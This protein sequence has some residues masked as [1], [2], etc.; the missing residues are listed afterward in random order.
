MGC[1]VMAAFLLSCLF[2]K[3]GT[4]S[5]HVEHGET[6]SRPIGN[7]LWF[8]LSPEPMSTAEDGEL[9]SRHHVQRTVTTLQQWLRLLF[10]V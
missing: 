8:C 1:R 6:F 5:G 9:L 3:G 4:L 7:K 10:M 2:A